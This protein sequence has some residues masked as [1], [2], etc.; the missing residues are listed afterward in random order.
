MMRIRIF[1]IVLSPIIFFFLSCGKDN[2]ITTPQIN[3]PS[4][5]GS[6]KWI[7]G[8]TF[9]GPGGIVLPHDDR[10]YESDNFLTFSDASS[11]AVKREY[12]KMAEESLAEIMTAFG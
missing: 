12:S 9:Y 5:G 4:G 1:I 10:I 3:Q 11:D 6:S 8:I 2:S 7:S